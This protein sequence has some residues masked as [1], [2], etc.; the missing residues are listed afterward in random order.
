M[1]DFFIFQTTGGGGLTV[2]P[3]GRVKVAD[4]NYRI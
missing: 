3:Q 1:V 4:C 2:V